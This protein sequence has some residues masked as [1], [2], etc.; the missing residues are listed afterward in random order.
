MS[1]RAKTK[2]EKVTDFEGYEAAQKKRPHSLT[3]AVSSAL[4]RIN[5][6]RLCDPATS[7]PLVSIESNTHHHLHLNLQIT[8]I[9]IETQKHLTLSGPITLRRNSDPHI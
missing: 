7:L 3:L 9:H 2:A 6:F 4:M 5:S 1:Y 8:Q